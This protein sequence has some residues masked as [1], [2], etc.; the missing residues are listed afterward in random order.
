MTTFD[1]DTWMQKHGLEYAGHGSKPK[2]CWVDLETTGLDADKDVVLEFGMVLTDEWGFIIP[3]SFYSS[4]VWENSDQYRERIKAMPD[5]VRKMHEKSGLLTALEDD[6]DGQ[7]VKSVNKVQRE[8]LNCLVDN[9]IEKGSLYLA[10]SSV[11]FDAGFMNHY[12][13]GFLQYLHYRQLNVSSFK[14][15]AQLLNPTLFKAMN[16]R[17]LNPFSAHRSLDDL[18]DSINEYASYIDNFLYT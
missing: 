18:G 15:A 10:G 2:L 6:T 12:M 17:D 9:D 4:L 8:A 5:F 14:V 3:D 1:P 7:T 11:H 13:Y 16:E